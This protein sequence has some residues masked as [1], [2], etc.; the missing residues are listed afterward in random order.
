MQATIRR[1]SEE[2]D[3][4]A[5]LA[6]NLLVLARTEEGH[7]PIHREDVSLGG[8]VAQACEGRLPSAVSA[9]VSISV[10]VSDGPARVDPIRLR[11]ALENLLD[12]A[13]RHSEPGGV[14]RVTGGGENGRAWVQVDDGGPGFASDVLPV[15]FEPFVRGRGDGTSA[16]AGLG[17]AIV[18]RV[19]TAHGGDAFAENLA[20]GGARVTLA[21]RI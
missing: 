5:R 14:V 1:A 19:A 7:L 18:R 21:F 9:N 4:L 15:A 17:L 11:Q 16:G 10:E 6:E 3:R 12:N 13:I 20:G 8:V 2:A